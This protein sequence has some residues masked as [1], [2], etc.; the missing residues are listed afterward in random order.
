MDI[1]D[2]GAARAIE[3]DT[4]IELGGSQEDR[5][6]PV[7]RRRV[8]MVVHGMGA[9]EQLL[10]DIVAE[11]DDDAERYRRP[12]RIAT[13]DPVLEAEDA[14]MRNAILPGLVRR[15]RNGGHMLFSGLFPQPLDQPVARGDEVGQGLLRAEG[16]GDGDDQGLGGIEPGQGERQFRTVDIGDEADIDPGPQRRQGLK[17]QARAEVGAADADMDQGFE[18]LSGGAG[19]RAR[20]DAVGIGLHLVA[21][22]LDVGGDLVAAQ[23]F[24]L[25]V[26]ITKRDVQHGAAFGHI[27]LL[28]GPHLLARR[29]DAR[30]VDRGD[31]GFEA[32]P[33]PGLLG[34]VDVEAADAQAHAGQAFGIGGELVDD[35]D[36]GVGLSLSFKGVGSHIY[37]R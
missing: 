14:V 26:R 31:G 35:L 2:D 5:R 22:R 15:G 37:L 28:A 21:R 12:Q 25:G 20:L 32:G 36:V 24:V 3:A 10:I 11:R 30:G 1:G 27:D 7:Q 8:E 9:V 16:L 18:R 13:A 6:V 4:V 23:A 34:D 33:C 19:N 29:G 17:Q